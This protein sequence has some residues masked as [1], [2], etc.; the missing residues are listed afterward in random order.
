[1]SKFACWLKVFYRFVVLK[2]QENSL[3]S[4][5]KI[6]LP[7]CK[8]DNIPGYAFKRRAYRFVSK[9]ARYILFPQAE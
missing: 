9:V 8:E 4:P 5:K 3:L 2:V 7:S 6:C 1:M